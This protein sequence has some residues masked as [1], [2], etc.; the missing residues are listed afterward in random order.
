MTLRT[1]LAAAFATLALGTAAYAANVIQTG[2]SAK[3]A[4][5]TDGAGMSL[6]TFD[7]D[8]AAVSNCYD[9]CAKN[10]PPLEAKSN[11]KPQGEFGIIIRADGSRQWTHKGMPLYTWFK[12]AAAGDIT[13]DGVKDV[14]HLARP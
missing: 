7:K 6:Y 5:L 8:T 10:W 9:D 2:D 13:G 3:G 4:I 12:D 11:S 14:W 1:T